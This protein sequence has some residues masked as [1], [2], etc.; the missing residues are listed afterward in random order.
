MNG[1]TQAPS[2]STAAPAPAD[3]RRPGKKHRHHP[4]R[5]RQPRQSQL[6]PDGSSTGA[7][8]SAAHN[9]LLEETDELGVKTTHDYD[10]RGNRTRTTEALGLPEQRITDYTS[11][12]SASSPPSREGGAVTLPMAAASAIAD[13]TT[14]FEYD[15]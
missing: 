2:S 1:K 4:G 10:Q 14:R 7:R 11:T 9:G 12:P 5:I 3:H 8:Y 6:P 13:A 15:A